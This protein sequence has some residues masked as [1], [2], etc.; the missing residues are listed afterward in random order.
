MQRTY[1]TGHPSEVVLV[2]SRFYSH[3][4]YTPGNGDGCSPPT[5]FHSCSLSSVPPFSH[6][7]L[8]NPDLL[9]VSINFLLLDLSG[10]W[11]HTTRGLSDVFLSLILLFSGLVRVVAG[12]STSFLFYLKN[13]LFTVLSPVQFF[14]SCTA[15]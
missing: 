5:R 8:C 2:H 6:P 14:P 7:A 12:M 13:F 3:T 15:G 4:Y 9:S 10:K 11:N 1:H